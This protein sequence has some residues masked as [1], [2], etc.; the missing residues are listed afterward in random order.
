[1]STQVEVSE[2]GYRKR[3]IGWSQVVSALLW[4]LA[5]LSVVLVMLAL[6]SIIAASLPDTLRHTVAFGLSMFACV[7]FGLSWVEHDSRRIASF[8]YGTLGLVVASSVY[9]I[10]HGAK[11]STMMLENIADVCMRL[12]EAFV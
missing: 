8:E 7:C 9:D 12:I 4:G 6:V 3:E 10:A 2:V 1:M 5:E 11:Y